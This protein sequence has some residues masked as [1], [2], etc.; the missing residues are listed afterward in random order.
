MP[1]I[2]GGTRRH[3]SVRPGPST[4]PDGQGRD[5]WHRTALP[6]DRTEW[7][8]RRCRGRARTRNMRSWLRSVA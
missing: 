5:R 2:R 3:P 8:R 4:E 6:N 1:H 7:R